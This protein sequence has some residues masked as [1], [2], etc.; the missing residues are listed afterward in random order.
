MLEI[1]TSYHYVQV[2]GKLINQTWENDKKATFGS[3]FGPFGTNLHPKSC[4]VDF[5]S[6]TC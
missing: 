1:V 6:T 4:F 5:T 3:D 2:H